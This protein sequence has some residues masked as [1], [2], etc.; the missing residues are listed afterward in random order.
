MVG[1]KNG[2]LCSDINKE[3]CCIECGNFRT[4][5]E[6]CDIV[7]THRGDILDICKNAYEIVEGNNKF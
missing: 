1:C 2:A 6:P 4:C 3:L 7:G 5:K